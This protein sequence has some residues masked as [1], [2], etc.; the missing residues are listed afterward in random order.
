MK[1][2]TSYN[3]RQLFA[4][5][6]KHAEKPQQPMNDNESSLLSELF[7][8]G[9]D[10]AENRKEV[11][12]AIAPATF[13]GLLVT[14]FVLL[15][16]GVWAGTAP[17]DSAAIADGSVALYEN[18]KTIQHL[19]GGIISEILVKEGDVVTKGQPLIVLNATSANAQQQLLMGQLQ[20]AQA[21]EARLKSERD[22]LPEIAFEGL[23]VDSTSPEIMDIINSQKH[24]F[25][26]RRAAIKGQVDILQERIMQYNDKIAGLRTQI[27]EV[28]AQSA[29]IAEEV[30]TVSDLLKRGLEQKPRL[31][32]L[33]RRQS[34]LKAAKAAH[35]ADIATTQGGISE[36]QLQIIY[37]QNEYL[38]EVMM[39]LRDVQQQVADVKER[40]SASGDILD[41]TVITA[42]QSGK[43]N[44]LRYHT[45]GGVIA[46]GAP[47]MDIV[48]Q[49]DKLIVEARVKPEDIDIVHEGLD[50]KVM[51]TAYK[52][53]FVP[54][55]KGK[56][57]QLSADIFT[58]EKTGISY[59]QARIEIDKSDLDSLS[60]KVELYP[61]MP[62]ESF[63]RT[64][65]QTLLD[66]LI[67]PVL[68]SFRRSFKEQ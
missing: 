17:L 67:S 26:T 16:F 48:P 3:I 37:L 31:L 57:I 40:L 36:A 61:G 23:P 27:K 53:R 56:V 54:R 15:F 38:K 64:G 41:R 66:Y 2:N 29:L 47:V 55:L 58:D 63:I 44:G 42:Q 39:E 12:Q 6:M 20:A 68:D 59:Y 28:E 50:A 52:S 14:A 11:R 46:P 45:I 35:Q 33:Q 4:R 13:Q 5:G 10:N 62:A 49:N 24:L 30:A 34:E 22:D 43:V 7:S 21:V 32:A 18:R 8:A 9:N 19:E 25:E 1:E 65:E 51:L 60:G